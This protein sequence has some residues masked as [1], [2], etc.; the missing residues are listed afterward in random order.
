[1]I[2]VDGPINFPG[3][4]FIDPNLVPASDNM[5]LIVDDVKPIPFIVNLKPA[6]NPCSTSPD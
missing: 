1:M 3:G 4:P 2:P 6:G 5:H